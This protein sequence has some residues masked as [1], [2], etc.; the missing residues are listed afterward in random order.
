[1][2]DSQ[3]A[4]H[5]VTATVAGSSLTALWGDRGR[6]DYRLPETDELEVVDSVKKADGSWAQFGRSTLKRKDLARPQQS[7]TTRRPTC[8]SW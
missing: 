4:R 3:G 8:G 2:V 7:A 6:T 5:A 1:M